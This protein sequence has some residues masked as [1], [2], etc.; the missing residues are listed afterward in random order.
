MIR[1]F[2]HRGLHALRETTSREG[3]AVS[4]EYGI[5]LVLIA[6]AIIAAATAFGMAVTGLFT[7][8]ST[9]VSGA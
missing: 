5:L 4:T 6:L 3:G 1:S 9:V 2:I 8:G 7:H